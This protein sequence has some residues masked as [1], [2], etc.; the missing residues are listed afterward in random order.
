MNRSEIISLY[1]NGLGYTAIA[2]MFGVSR[3]CVEQLVNRKKLLARQRLKYAIEN[4]KVER[5]P[6]SQCGEQNA[7]AHHED[8]DK[9]LEVIW[10]CRKHHTEIHSGRTYKTA[11]KPTLAA[12]TADQK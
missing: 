9:P 8:Y 2:R 1:Q 10:L 7:E 12:A 5:Q 6:C 4:G 11:S 3:Q